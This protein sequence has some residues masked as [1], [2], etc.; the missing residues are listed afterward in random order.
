[1][2][3]QK[4]LLV[5][6]FAFLTISAFAQQKYEKWGEVSEED[7]KMTVYPLDSS[8]SAVILQ[9]VGGINV[10][11]LNQNFQV[12]YKIHRRIKIL[13]ASA[14]DLGNLTFQ[15]PSNQ[16]SAK[17][18][19]LD[20]QMFL[21]T[22]KK[23]KVRSD[24]IYTE[25]ISPK[26]TAKKIF[27]PNL[28]KGCIIE[29]RYEI[30]FS[31]IEV[32]PSWYFQ[33][34]LPVRWS[35]VTI[36]H[37]YLLNYLSLTN[38]P[39]PFDVRETKDDR[40]YDDVLI[41]KLVRTRLGIGNLPAFKEEPYM[42]TLDDYRA[43]IQFYLK[44]IF[45]YDAE[46][47][48]TKSWSDLADKMEKNP[49]FGEK[50][51]KEEKF[52]ALWDAFS[53]TLAPGTPKEVLPELALRFVSKHIKWN[54][55]YSAVIYKDLDEIFQEKTGSTAEINLALVALLQKAGLDALP[56]LL[57]TRSNGA[58]VPAYLFLEQFNSV[59]AFV[60]ESDTTGILLDATDPYHALN[61]MQP[62]HYN[63]A[64]WL[65]D[66]KKPNWVNI[67]PPEYGQIWYGNLRLEEN[68]DMEGKFSL[69]VSGPG[70][71]MWRVQLDQEG[72]D[73]KVLKKYFAA[74]YPNASFDS[75]AFSDRDSC[76]KRLAVNFRCRIPNT[77]AIVNSYLYCKP[78]LGFI[79]EAN[80][81]K[82]LK[83]EFPVSFTYPLRAQ[84]V[85]ILET[86]PGYTI[87]DQSEPFQV[88]L[89]NGGGKLSF[90]CGR[91]PDGKVQLSLKVNLTQL[92]FTPE[93]YASLRKFFELIAEKTQTQ[94]VLVKKQAE[95]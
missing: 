38:I 52:N 86:P 79:V 68:G 34:D 43:H 73:Q 18:L 72:D 82:T 42:T 81:F 41:Y 5:L 78:V 14:F 8:A 4:N 44:S 13:D 85:L 40:G 77:A 91:T 94:L 20:V 95:K 67:A 23:Q 22:G 50:Y 31:N 93:E 19:N 36:S 33:Y 12:V 45:D 54:G 25:Q 90:R 71:S 3:T 56:M 58:P 87:E 49:Y 83:R 62:Q 2:A 17:F 70:A 37:P 76:N 89:Q 27:V 63:G 51:K 69:A 48:Q 11:I 1:M 64:G 61:E 35:E 9:D 30:Q 66:P 46:E 55:R 53:S 80:P 60:R 10:E 59:A 92:E 88:S 57:S 24:N 21:P 15:Y 47:D 7:L 65:V 28:Q 75:I 26:W 74:N 39:R 6:F 16:G 32:L 29:F 84:Y